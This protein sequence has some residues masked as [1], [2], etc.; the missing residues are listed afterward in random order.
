M[1]IEDEIEMEKC[2]II[3]SIKRR[4][5]QAFLGLLKIRNSDLLDIYKNQYRTIRTRT[6]KNKFQKNVLKDVYKITRFPAK[7]TR[8]DLALLLNHTN[9]GIQIWFQNQRNHRGEVKRTSVDLPYK[10]PHD[11][12]ICDVVDMSTIINII[13]DNLPGTMLLFWMKFINYKPNHYQ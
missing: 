7:Q 13:E 4:N 10:K 11:R 1:N 3:N 6:L 8:D 9:R 2:V 12:S 5:L